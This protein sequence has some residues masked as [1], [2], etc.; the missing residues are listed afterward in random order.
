MNYTPPVT[1][2]ADQCP[3]CPAAGLQPCVRMRGANIGQTLH[4]GTTR[5]IRNDH[6][7]RPTTL[8]NYDR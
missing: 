3:T 1:G 8:V 7:N 4:G 5:S 2:P 6:T